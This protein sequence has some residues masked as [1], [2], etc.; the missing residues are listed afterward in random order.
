MIELKDLHKSFDGIEVLKGISTSFEPG[1][2]NLIIGASGGG[3]KC[4]NEVYGW[5][6]ATYF[7]SDLI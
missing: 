1:R 7:W 3:K 2:T 4:I 6:F 5:T